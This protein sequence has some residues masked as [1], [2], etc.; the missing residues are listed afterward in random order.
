[1]TRDK[2]LMM[3]VLLVGVFILVASNVV[4][5]EYDSSCD[6][7]VVVKPVKRPVLIPNQTLV[8]A[9]PS[10]DGAT[11]GLAFDGTYLWS[12]DNGDGNS[13]NGPKIYKLDANTGAILGSYTTP[14][15][16]YPNGLTWDGSYLWHS[17]HGTDSIYKIDT[18]SMTA[19]KSFAS[20]NQLPRDL[21]WDGENLYCV[22]GQ[23]AII[24][25]IDTATGTEIDTI[26]CDYS[27]PNI[28]PCG[29]AYLP[30]STGHQLWT[31]DG[32]YGSNLVH[33]WDF[34]TTSWIGQWAADPAYYPSGLAYDSVSGYLWVSCWTNDSIY[35]FDVGTS[36]IAED[37]E[38][39]KEHYVL[40]TYPNP[41]SSFVDIKYVLPETEHITLRIYD[42]S[43]RIV[44]T[45]YDGIQNNGE[46]IVHWNTGSLASGIYFTKFETGTY[47]QT[48]KITIQR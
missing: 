14:G 7:E 11:R 44:R 22:R 13:V 36:A 21:A 28:F 2:L 46:H 31:S 41:T 34:A 16:Y 30:F 17:D 39:D 40:V 48:K 20:P 5:T 42:I 25:V 15:D 6:K 1:M 47:S 10:P 19:V 35:V 38:T 9:F 4:V 12:A 43:G 24:S 32:N 23:D 27:S 18:T 26:I 33:K 8:G 45:L 3:C 37:K 29:L